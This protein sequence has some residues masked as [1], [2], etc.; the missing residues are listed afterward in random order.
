[1][2]RN[3][4]WQ[5]ID[6]PYLVPYR[7]TY[8]R[9][10]I[11]SATL[12]PFKTLINSPRYDFNLR[13]LSKFIIAKLNFKDI[14]CSVDLSNKRVYNMSS[15]INK[16]LPRWEFTGCFAVESTFNCKH[17]NECNYLKKWLQQPMKLHPQW[18]MHLLLARNWWLKSIYGQFITWFQNQT[19]RCI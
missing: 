4:L 6:V 5:S 17:L 12:R 8:A 2:F 19:E 9:Q 11:R 14:H 15:S 1:M 7:D 3:K 13:F 10:F 16:N 18:W